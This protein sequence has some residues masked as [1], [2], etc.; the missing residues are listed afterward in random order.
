MSVIYLSQR[1]V[2]TTENVKGSSDCGYTSWCEMA[3]FMDPSLGT[4]KKVAEMVADFEP[5]IG[6]KGFGNFLVDSF[7]WAD[8]IFKK[9]NRIGSDLRSYVE[10]SKKIFP[11][12]KVTHG[13]PGSWAEFD[14]ILLQGFPVMLFT[15]LAGDIK[16]GTG[17]HFVCV[18]GKN[19]PFY[20]VQD[21]WGNAMTGYK[22]HDGKDSKY[23]IEF[24]RSKVGPKPYYL[25]IR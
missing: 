6:P 10:Y 21:P 13:N 25:A 11:T 9:Q 16:K 20:I 15:F 17:A 7:P 22:N 1:N 18:S 8:S 24:L 2:E 23:P 14:E 19:D 5:Y 12:A 4:L 3:S